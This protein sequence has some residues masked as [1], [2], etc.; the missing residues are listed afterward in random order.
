MAAAVDANNHGIY[1]S[2]NSGVTWTLTSAPTFPGDWAGVASSADGTKLAAVVGLN[3]GGLYTSGDSGGTWTLT[4]APTNNGG[5]IT[6]TSSADGTKLAAAAYNSIYISSDS[7]L[8]WTQPSAMGQ[9]WQSL[10]SSADGTKMAAV[11]GGGGI[12]TAQAAIQTTTT[13]GSAGY[14]TG[15]Q[16]SAIELQYIGNG[17]FL[18]L[19][20][21][22]TISAY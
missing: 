21:S 3:P 15:G 9:S 10:T 13:P 22:G 18:P 2:T 20:Y 5:W 17:Q 12:W 1:T 14:L 16:N 8:T 7:G 19:S 4:S 6:I 11:T